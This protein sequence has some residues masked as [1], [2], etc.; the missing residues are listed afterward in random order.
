MTPQQRMRAAQRFQA[1][2]NSQPKLPSRLKKEFRRT[3]ANLV[4]HFCLLRHGD[5][6]NPLPLKN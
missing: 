6:C 1:R 5:G 2:A 4:K 3:A